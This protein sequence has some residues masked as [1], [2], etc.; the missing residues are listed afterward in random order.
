MG[1]AVGSALVIPVGHNGTH[2]CCFE[3]FFFYNKA[4]SRNQSAVVCLTL[5][6]A[7]QQ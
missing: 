6:L 4:G 1:E 5:G 2:A 3:R 7:L